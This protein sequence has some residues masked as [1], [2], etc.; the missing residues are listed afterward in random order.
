M[1]PIDIYALPS[2]DETPW[3]STYGM[4]NEDLFDDDMFDARIVTQRAKEEGADALVFERKLF[5]DTDYGERTISYTAVRYQG[6]H[7][8]LLVNAGRGERDQK[9]RLVTDVDGWR[10]A[11]AYVERFADPDNSV[12][13]DAVPTDAEI[14]VLGGIYGYSVTKV[15]DETR[16]V[17]NNDIDRKGR[18]VFDKKAYDDAFDRIVRPAF[19]GGMH[20]EEFQEGL[21]G[22]RMRSLAVE[23][24]V[25]SLPDWVRST[26]EFEPV[27]EAEG[28]HRF[29]GWSPVLVGT[30]EGT[31]TVGVDAYATEARY[32][33][34]GRN[35]GLERVGPPEMYDELAPSAA[36]AP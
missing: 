27:P 12:E 26:T 36:P 14:D 25:A 1:R 31:Y 3:H 22:E 24:I 5:A 35:L 10:A 13:R 6:E 17:N 15:G 30:D 18:V 7:I 20:E 16:L 4:Q 33:S 8:A 9:Y 28:V 34:W 21:K 29:Q 23:A 19:K 11:R 32:F 2:R